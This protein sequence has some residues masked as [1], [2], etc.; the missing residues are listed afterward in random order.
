MPLPSFD[1]LLLPGLVGVLGL[2]YLVA[3][4]AALM[5]WLHRRW[6]AM[7]KVERLLSYGL[8]FLLFPGLILL[9]PFVNLRPAGRHNEP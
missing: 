1:N 5:A 9:A 4:P 2:T 3:A 7:G 6:H 8:V